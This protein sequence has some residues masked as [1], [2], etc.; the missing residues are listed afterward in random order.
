MRM[1]HLA[2][3]TFA[4]LALTTTL[5]TT[6][7]TTTFAQ[8]APA[9]VTAGAAN[10]K[11]TPLQKFD[12]PGTNSETITAVAEIVPNVLIGKHMHFG[13]ETGYVLSGDVVLMVAGQPDLALKAGDSFQIPANAPHDAKSGANRTK[14][15]AVYIVEKGKPLATPVQ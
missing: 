7:T 12:V 3:T 10:I 8:S 2:V 9:A 4:A 1:R 14:L 15:L 11:R 6:P 13:I 5:S